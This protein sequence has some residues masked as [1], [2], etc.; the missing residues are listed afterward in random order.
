VSAS[1][2]QDQDSFLEIEGDGCCDADGG[3]EG[4]GAS[5]VAHCDPA[6]VLELGE[7]VLDAMALLIEGSVI[8]DGLLAAFGRRG[9]GFGPLSIRAWRNQ[10]LS[11]PRSAS[12]VLV[13][14]RA[15]SMI[16]APL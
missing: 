1:A 10:L 11:Y 7:H 2:N 6:P 14:G 3:E 13:G 5:V 8:G 12:N 15:S 4:V 9:A 16:R